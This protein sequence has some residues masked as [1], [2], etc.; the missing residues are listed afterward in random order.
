LIGFHVRLVV[1]I[2]AL[3]LAACANTRPQSG[4]LVPI[5]AAAGVS[6]VSILAATTRWAVDS[7]AMFSGERMSPRR[8][9]HASVTVSVP[10]VHKPGQIEWPDK[11]PGNPA[12]HFTTAARAYLTNADFM[13]ALDRAL[14]SR[15]P[16]QR[17]ILL[18]VHGYNTFFDEA[19]YRLAQFTNDSRYPGVPVLF[20]LASRGSFWDY[21]YDRDSASAARDA[22]EAMLWEL[23]A[24][25]HV[26]R[27]N[28]LAHSIGNLVVMEALRQAAIRGDATF[29]GKIGEIV[30]AAPDIDVDVFRTQL[31][32]LGGRMPGPTVLFVSDDDGA[33]GIV[34]SLAGNQPRLGEYREAA[35]FADA[36][37]TVIDISKVDSGDTGMM[38]HDKMFTS[39]GLAQ[40]VGSGLARG[41]RLDTAGRDDANSWPGRLTSIER[42]LGGAMRGI[43][44]AILVTPGS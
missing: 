18:F 10:P 28:I 38:G 6:Q 44:G 36:G 16:A 13:A 14:A 20:S 19:V 8:V 15:P 5:G 34:N 42:S 21:L 31:D 22:L 25:P 33:L 12:L 27:I 11:A 9:A 26:G 29:R 23:A 30:M 35:E 43:L 1:L 7:P 2:A 37:I 41:D 4:A 32:A 40:L 17:D 24:D 3:A 39:Q